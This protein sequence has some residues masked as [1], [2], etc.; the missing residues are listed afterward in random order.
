VTAKKGK[1]LIVDDEPISVQ[2]L[3]C[4]LEHDY[5]VFMVK[6]GKEALI[7]AEAERPDVILLDIVM[8]EMDGYEVIAHLRSNPD[9]CAIPVLFITSMTEEEC[10]AKGLE[11]G[12]HDYLRKPYNA[13]TVRLR[14]KNHLEFKRHHDVIKEQRDLLEQKN[15]ELEAAL[16]R[17]KR[18]EGI[19]TICMYCKQIRSNSDSWH[20]LEQYIT[21]HSEARFSHGI[22]PACVH[23]FTE[24]GDF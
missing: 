4:L 9:L 14:V 15:D 20:Q 6:N 7:C 16:A 2:T 22:C 10:E 21:E 24:S 13:A 12:A 18:L 3:L 19:V 17:I 5:D 23:K 1:V 11:L 8:P